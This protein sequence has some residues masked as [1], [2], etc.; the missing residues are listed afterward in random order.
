MVIKRRRN[1]LPTLII[2]LLFWFS[3][4]YIV[5]HVPPE[6]SLSLKTFG[7][8]LNLPAGYLF[9]FLSLIL[10]LTLTFAF[11]FTNTRRGLFLS[12]F[13]NGVLLFR[14]LKQ[15]QLQNL[16]LLLAILICFEIYFSKKAQDSY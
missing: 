5:L 11:L 3:W 15:L 13:L 4:L 2:N 9:F 16:I 14:L 7:L 6:Y 10:A 1:F 8:N 12:L